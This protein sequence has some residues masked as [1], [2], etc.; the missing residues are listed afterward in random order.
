MAMMKEGRPYM[1]TDENIYNV[2]KRMSEAMGFK[3]PELFFA[4]PEKISP[5]AK[6]PPPSTDMMKIQADSQESQAKLQF[7]QQKEPFRA[8]TEKA[9][10]QI[11]AQTAI[12]VAQIGAQTQKEIAA[13]KIQAEG[14]ALQAQ[15]RL[16]VFDKQNTLAGEHAQLEH[17]KLALS[18]AE[19]N[20]KAALESRAKDIAH[21]EEIL[22]LKGQVD[23]LKE[24]HRKE[25]EKGSDVKADARDGKSQKAIAQVATGLEGVVKPLVSIQKILDDSMAVQK[26]LLEAA[27]KPRTNSISN[28]QMDAKGRV[29]GATVTPTVQ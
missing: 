14:Q 13:M 26:A 12:A 19:Q 27:L 20:A 28:V 29:T 9:I 6:K 21:A 24:Q 22:S 5:E 17:G 11:T 4:D 8:E 16:Q 1:V 3:H 23:A 25:I 18:S 15:A 2:S 7:E 10:A